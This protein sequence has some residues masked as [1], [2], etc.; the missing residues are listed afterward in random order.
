M[1][2]KQENSNMELWHAVATTDAENTS[3]F[4]GKGGFQGTAVAAQSQIMKATEL[5]GPMGYEWGL[6][7]EKYFIEKR[8]EFDSRYNV[9]IFSANLFYP[10]EGNKVS[11]SLETEIDLW[12]FSAKFKSWSKN[13]DTRKKSRT[14]L[15]T[16]ALSQLGFNADIFMGKFEDNGYINSINNE[17]QQKERYSILYSLERRFDDKPDDREAAYEEYSNMQPSEIEDS[18]EFFEKVERKDNAI[19]YVS[20]LFDKQ[21]KAKSVIDGQMYPLDTKDG[22][23]EILK[24]VSKKYGMIEEVTKMFTEKVES[25]E[26]EVS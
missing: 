8:S 11:I 16:K 15:L 12:N 5:W 4:K 6:E 3:N 14:D 17:K 21:K 25:L 9:L 20:K 2:E 10:H 26:S 24:S 18:I 23:R 7:N 19:K 22:L 1:A 13:N